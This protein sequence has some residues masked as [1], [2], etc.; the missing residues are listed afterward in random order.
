MLKKLLQGLGFLAI[1][2][3]VVV[4]FDKLSRTG[5]EKTHKPAVY[6]DLALFGA[7]DAIT[8]PGIMDHV[9]NQMFKETARNSDPSFAGARRTAGIAPGGTT[10]ED[11]AS[12]EGV[13]N[14]PRPS[15]IDD[16]GDSDASEQSRARLRRIRMLEIKRGDRRMY[17]NN[18]GGTL[19]SAYAS[20]ALKRRSRRAPSDA[21]IEAELSGFVNKLKRRATD[22][23]RNNPSVGSNLDEVDRLNTDEGDLLILS[24]DGVDSRLESS[25]ALRALQQ[26]NKDG[27]QSLRM[28]RR[29]GMT[30]GSRDK[31]GKRFDGNEKT[32]D[33]IPI[34]Q[35][36]GAF[37]KKQIKTYT[38]S[39]GPRD[40]K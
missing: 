17:G 34:E 15:A 12:R 2:S 28:S 8:G 1:I 20:P 7:T 14:R 4:I 21:E 11:A 29:G 16:T 23:A 26:L 39:S 37:G 6:A 33:S 35:V 31:A 25:P 40:L 3:I 19:P 36:T 27:A 22:E 30:D 10:Y 24:L 13:L 38:E 9:A 18:G 5:P 32:M